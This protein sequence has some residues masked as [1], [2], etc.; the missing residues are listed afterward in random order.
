RAGHASRLRDR[1]GTG[2]SRRRLR[3]APRRGAPETPP[4]GGGGAGGAPRAG[5]GQAPEGR[6]QSFKATGA[7]PLRRELELFLA[8]ARDG[9][10]PPVDVAAGLTA[11]AVVEAALRS[12][13]LGRRVTL[14]EL[15]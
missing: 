3:L 9:S 7:E 5:A 6:T 13:T 10:A 4:R 8:A 15:V 11:L 14:A 1:G 12:S 2:D